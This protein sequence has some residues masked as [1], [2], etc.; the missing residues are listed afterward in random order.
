MTTSLKSFV[1]YV[2]C[3]AAMACLAAEDGTSASAP[4]GD[5]VSRDSSVPESQLATPS[6]PLSF[7]GNRD[8]CLKNIALCQ[9]GCEI[10][11]NRDDDAWLGCRI[12]CGNSGSCDTPE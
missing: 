8:K 9:R 4:R 1:V 12:K 7:D 5:S 3:I 6:A 11:R 2:A 10:Y